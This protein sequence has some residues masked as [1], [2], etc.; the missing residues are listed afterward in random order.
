MYLIENLKTDIKKILEKMGY[1]EEVVITPSNRPDLGDYQ[2]NG[3]MA[4]AGKNHMNPR[5]LAEKI[6]SEL[7]QNDKYTNLNVAGPGFI[8]ITFSDE[9]LITYMNDIHEDYEKNVYKGDGKTILLDYGGAN[10]AKELHVGHLRSANIGEATNRLLKACG[11]NTIS[12]V[13]LGDWGRPMGLVILEIKNRMPDLPYFDESFAGEYPTESPVT[14]EDLAE[15]YPYASAKSK[16]DENYLNEA[17]AITVDLQKGKRGYRALWQHIVKTSGDDIKK[18]YDLLNAEFDLWEGEA[19]AD[20][21]IPELLEYLEKGNYTEISN[22]AEVIFVNEEGD[23]REIPPFM[24]K[25]SDG[26]VLY[27]TTEL[28]TI[29]ARTKRFK[30]D[31]IWYFTDIRQELHFVQTF[32]AAYKTKIV[33]E[34][35]PLVHLGFGTMNGK[36]GKPFKTRDGGVL[37]LKSLYK[38]VYDECYKKI[39][40]NVAES[41]KEDLARI[42]SVAAI[43]YADLLPNRTTD[44]IF[45]PEK[46]SDLNGKTGPYL[47]YNTVR[48][49]SILKKAEETDLSY[50]KYTAISTEKEREIILHLIGLSEVLKRG[51]DQKLLNEICEYIFK[52]TNLYN[53]FYAEH[54][55]LSEQD[56]D[57][58]ES[59][60]TM[61]DLV[62]KTNEFILNILGIEIPEKM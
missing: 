17:R 48:I 59:W 61:S 23:A 13:H 6:V 21:Y 62:L 35:M 49:K 52:L 11:Y 20:E 51:I 36:D 47:L 9:V 31:E 25:K 1:G 27:D 42:V 8:N 28:A 41:E 10:I 32:R 29:Y 12:D 60:L 50:K 38:L 37:S 46:F 57:K 33:P 34:N 7:S 26:G 55:I 40:D 3:C 15:I 56:K 53:S 14:A 44:Y 58:Q 4:I 22:G 43:K 30:L 2:Y 54:Y 16:E 45:D 19:A 39:G 5:E 18:I 24:L